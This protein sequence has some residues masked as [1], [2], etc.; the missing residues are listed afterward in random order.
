MGKEQA[1]SAAGNSI[2]E[3][4]RR[5]C[6]FLRRSRRSPR[7]PTARRQ[8]LWRPDMKTLI[9]ALTLGTL[10]VAPAFAQ[11]NNA[12]FGSR[13]RA[14]YQ[15]YDAV[16]PLGSPTDRRNPQST[17]SHGREAAVHECS[18]SSRRYLETTWGNMQMFQFRACMM[19]HG[20]A[21]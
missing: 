17:G 16:T 4:Q 8:P 6:D 14:A 1:R 11:S 19:V 15:A 2:Q 13:S 10:I 5:F 18:L 12:D 3:D 9:A 21:E 7:W 20:Q